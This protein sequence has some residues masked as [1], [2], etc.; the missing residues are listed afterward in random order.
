MGYVLLFVGVVVFPAFG[1]IGA[2][3]LLL[4]TFGLGLV[5]GFAFGTDPIGVEYRGLPMVLTAISGRQFVRGILVAALGVGIP[6]IT[7]VILPLGLLSPASHLETIALVCFGIAICACTASVAVAA[8]MDV[9]RSRLVP[10]PF[11]FTDVP[12]YAEIGSAAFRRMG[13]TF[14]ILSLVA[15]P[16]VFGNT[17]VVYEGIAT[18]GVPVLAVR[19]SALL[20]SILV[21]G[22]VSRAACRIAMRRFRTYRLR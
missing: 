9:E 22:W 17:V 6:L 1:L 12:V 19:L 18:A 4:V 11:F 21:A 5:A 3:G 15:L 14:G 16:A 8:G 20:V 13:R 10:V 7:V 2:P